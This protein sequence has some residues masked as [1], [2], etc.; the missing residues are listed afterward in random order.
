MKLKI[1]NH[2]FNGTTYEIILDGIDG[3]ASNPQGILVINTDLDTRNGLETAIHEALH[4]CKWDAVEGTVDKTARD[5][6][7]FLWRLNFRRQK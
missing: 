5:V 2:T 7:R 4:C 3:C 6:A 1:K